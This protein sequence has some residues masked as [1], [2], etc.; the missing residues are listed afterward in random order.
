LATHVSAGLIWWLTTTRRGDRLLLTDRL[1]GHLVVPNVLYAGTLVGSA[2]CL[3]LTFALVAQPSLLLR[4]VI[5]LVQAI[6]GLACLGLWGS[7]LAL[8]PGRPAWAY[9]L[10]VAGS[11]VLSF[12]TGILDMLA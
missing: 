1:G 7:S 10:A 3:P 9:W 8:Q 12:Q 4:R 11:V 5:R 2:C 6:V